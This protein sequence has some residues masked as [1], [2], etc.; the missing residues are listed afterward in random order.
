M[1]QE[2]DYNY[3]MNVVL[4]NN[5]DKANKTPSPDD[6]SS[7]GEHKSNR[8]ITEM[9]NPNL[10]GTKAGHRRR[11]LSN[12]MLPLMWGAIAYAIFSQISV[13]SSRVYNN[14]RP[15]A[16]RSTLKANYDVNVIGPQ[17]DIE[18]GRM[19]VLS[20]LHEVLRV[21]TIEKTP[22][23]KSMTVISSKLY[24]QNFDEQIRQIRD[25]LQDLLGKEGAGVHETCVDENG[26]IYVYAGS[27][28]SSDHL[29]YELYHE[30]LGHLL[31]REI[32]KNN[33]EFDMRWQKIA[34]RPD[35][36]SPYKD[37]GDVRYTVHADQY[38]VNGQIVNIGDLGFLSPACMDNWREDACVMAAYART[39]PSSFIPPLFGTD[40]Q[41]PNQVII[42]KIQLAQE[43]GLIRPEFTEAITL[44]RKIMKETDIN[45][46]VSLT[47]RIVDDNQLEIIM[48]NIKVDIEHFMKQYPNS[49][50]LS[51]ICLNYSSFIYQNAIRI[52]NA[53]SAQRFANTGLDFAYQVLNC[54]THSYNEYL[55]A[56]L[57][58][59]KLHGKALGDQKKADIFNQ[60]YDYWNTKNHKNT[61]SL[62]NIKT[63][64]LSKGIMAI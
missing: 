37:D 34:E 4:I 16:E 47:P 57:L 12:A 58:L 59:A 55:S 29:L 41:K 14:L 49:P 11:S 56:L 40:F 36:K 45:N 51:R 20:A 18:N 19:K 54:E 64:L 2:K 17:A 1:N 28:R 43:Y 61:I 8:G 42:D 10:F 52:Q 31:Q 62:D 46:P 5:D 23:P 7:N 27:F 24:L 35:G 25:R 30:V 6:L 60:A 48:N 32:S 53:E 50:Y 15:S 39:Q 22:L 38:S 13:I 44:L 26:N 21:A 3:P 9:L 63:F 33:P